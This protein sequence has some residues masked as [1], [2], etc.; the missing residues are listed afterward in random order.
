[1]TETSETPNATEAP[2]KNSQVCAE[3]KEMM[4]RKGL[5][6]KKLVG[7][8]AVRIRMSEST[9]TRIMK[10]ERSLSEMN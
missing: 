8:L 10:G 2:T 3:L 5:N 1:M 7:R 6:Q 9:M 4:K